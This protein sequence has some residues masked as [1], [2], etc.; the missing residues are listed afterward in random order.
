MNNYLFIHSLI[1]KKNLW[2][3]LSG[4]TL[5]H[6][7]MQVSGAQLNKAPSAQCVV[8][9][10]PKAKSLSVPVHAPS[11]HLHL[12][13]L[14]RPSLLAVTTLLSVS[15]CCMD[16]FFFFLLNPL[17]FFHLSPQS[18]SPLRAVSVFRGPMPLFLFCLPVY[19][20]H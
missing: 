17:T 11:A 20:V 3:E 1:F 6:K 16:M 13:L 9:P 18:P 2:I 8:H 14:P 4:V 5:V 10:W 7:T 12:P 19:L 15:M